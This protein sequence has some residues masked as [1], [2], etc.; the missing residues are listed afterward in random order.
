MLVYVTYRRHC[1]SSEIASFLDS[2]FK[3]TDSDWVLLR[4]RGGFWGTEQVSEFT[5]FL[6]VILIFS[7][8]AATESCVFLAFESP[9]IILCQL[10]EIRIKSK[11]DLKTK[12]IGSDWLYLYILLLLFKVT[13]I[14]LSWLS[15]SLVS[16]IIFS[17]PCFIS[18][19]AFSSFSSEIINDNFNLKNL[20]CIG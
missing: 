6:E 14:S 3:L 2:G 17:V 16:L 1:V 12:G 5:L 13:S 7:C 4:F 20:K 11:I 8:K 15:V 9:K 10:L 19:V 18:A